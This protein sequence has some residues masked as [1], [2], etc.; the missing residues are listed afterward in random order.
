MRSD[1]L[2]SLLP[3]LRKPLSNY[4]VTKLK[5]CQLSFVSRF[6]GACQEE[7]T[8]F[9]TDF[10]AAENSSCAI[11]ILSRSIT[12]VHYLYVY[13]YVILSRPFISALLYQGCILKSQGD[14]LWDELTEETAPM[15]LHAVTSVFNCNL[16]YIWLCTDILKSISGL[17]SS[18]LTHCKFAEFKTK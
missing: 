11:C 5:G 8:R 13:D 15:Q 2:Q 4:N 1:K 9:C 7:P 16:N 10:E 14:N 17:F 12:T 3:K 18:M 6:Y